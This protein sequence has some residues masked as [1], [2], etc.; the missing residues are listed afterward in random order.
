MKQEDPKNKDECPEFGGYVCEGYP[1]WCYAC[2]P[3]V[4]DIMSG[5]RSSIRS[6][7]TREEAENDWV[8]PCKPNAYQRS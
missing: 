3:S 5:K 1:G 7:R 6:I 4:P 2:P 8:E